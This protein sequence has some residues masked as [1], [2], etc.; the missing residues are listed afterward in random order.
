MGGRGGRVSLLAS[1]EIGDDKEEEEEEEVEK[2]AGMVR[3]SF[4]NR[5][6]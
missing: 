3:L 1:F 2:K 5:F 4:P 6:A